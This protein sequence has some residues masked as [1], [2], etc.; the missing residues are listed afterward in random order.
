MTAKN[1]TRKQ[2]DFFAKY[3]HPLWQ[4]KRL[5]VMRAAGFACVHCGSREDTLNVHHISYVKGRDPWEYDEH[6]LMCLCEGCHE[7]VTDMEDRLKGA[8]HEFKVAAYNSYHSSE[9]LTGY[10]TARSQLGPFRIR[11]VDDDLWLRG[12]LAGY[13]CESVL[14]KADGDERPDAFPRLR[15]LLAADDGF[16]DEEWL[17]YYAHD[18]LRSKALVDNIMKQGFYCPNGFPSW[19][20]ERVM[21]MVAEW[22]EVGE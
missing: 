13:E 19:Y 7:R 9:E 15:E 16:I 5:E 8:L 14:A 20:S 22:G 1:S 17:F 21:K 2:G 12:F 11:A 3:R 10:L 18:S 4:K 6:E